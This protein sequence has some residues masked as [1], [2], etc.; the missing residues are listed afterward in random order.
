MTARHCGITPLDGAMRDD[1][2]FWGDRKPWV[3]VG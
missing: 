2:I 1:L 3:K